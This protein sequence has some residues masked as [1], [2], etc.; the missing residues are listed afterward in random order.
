MTGRIVRENSESLANGTSVT[1]DLE[2]YGS[3]VFVLTKRTLPTPIVRSNRVLPPAVALDGGWTVRFGKD[4]QPVSM[5]KLRSWTANADTR[6]FSGVATYEKRVTVPERM[7]DNGL[8]VRLDFGPSKPVEVD[9]GRSHVQAWLDAPV[10]EA[11]VV[12]ING[13]RAGSTWCPPYNVELTGLL[14][15][16][17]N[18]LR[19][20][21]ANLAVN[22]MSDF[23]RRPLP[24]YSELMVRFG[25]RFQPQ[26]MNLI[27]PVPA[28]LMG[29][30]RII[31]TEV[32][33]GMPSK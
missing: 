22:Y 20:E 8:A 14:K 27:H 25:N 11:A 23:A 7:I 19:I 24:D 28:G 33:P 17:E 32:E 5:D 26:E 6:Y 10:R 31:A 4:A 18:D 1:I 15:E 3:R 12:Y 21:V 9:A 29:P 16:G 2:P 13:K 30:I